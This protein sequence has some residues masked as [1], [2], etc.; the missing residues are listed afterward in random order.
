[1]AGLIPRRRQAH[2]RLDYADQD[3]R[4]N[5]V[6]P[7]AILTANLA[8]AGPEP[9]QAAAAA[10]PLQRVGQPDDV[11]VAVLW[12]C[13]DDASFITGATLLV[14]GGKPAG[15]PPSDVTL[16]PSQPQRQKARR[17]RSP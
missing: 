8:R 3:I 9:Q 6:A 13:S 12:L 7:S 14:D 11:A 4:V 1:M 10:M 15:T 2:D 5:A 16:R 17:E